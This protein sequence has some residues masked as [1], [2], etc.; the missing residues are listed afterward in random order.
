MPGRKY[1]LEPLVKLRKRQVDGATEKLARA[2]NEREAAE[3]KRLAAE[4][5]VAE[6]EAAS[7]ALRDEERRALETGAL[8]VGDLQ[9]AQAWELGVAEA[10]KRL[11]EQV[12]SAAR[13]EG[14]ACDAVA[15]AQQELAT[16]EA[17]AEVVEKDKTRFDAKSARDEMNKEEEAAAEGGMR[18]TKDGVS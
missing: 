3:R 6:A 17:D 4:K 14:R 7:Q 11:T 1:P 2:I 10:G 15:S 16:R 9:R 13:D 18:K 12:S 5:A 8:R